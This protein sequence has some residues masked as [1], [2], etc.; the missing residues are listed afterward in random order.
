MVAKSYTLKWIDKILQRSSQGVRT[1]ENTRI[2]DIRPFRNAKWRE[3]GDSYS[4]ERFDEMAYDTFEEM[5]RLA[6]P[7]IVLVCQ[8]ETSKTAKNKLAT[9]LS[10]S[11]TS[12]GTLSVLEILGRK[13]IIVN[14][15]HPSYFTRQLWTKDGDAV[16]DEREPSCRWPDL[17]VLSEGL[18]EFAFLAAV[19]AAAGRK[20]SGFGQTNL[21]SCAL[22]GPVAKIE[23]VHNANG[24]QSTSVRLTYEWV[25][26]ADIASPKFIELLKQTP[27][28]GEMDRKMLELAD[29]LHQVTLRKK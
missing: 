6:K 2:F 21:S 9:A 27:F 12:A 15:F 29:L 24:E 23:P 19:N 14:G 28:W 16:A 13:T 3:E 10:S 4:R 18:L 8:C 17:S 26:E 20:I 7:D 5:I 1:W 11:V 25:S 22:H